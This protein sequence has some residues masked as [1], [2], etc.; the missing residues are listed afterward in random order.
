MSEALEQ[1]KLE[2]NASLKKDVLDYLAIST[3]K[4]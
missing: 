3:Y 2:K 4:V 1:L